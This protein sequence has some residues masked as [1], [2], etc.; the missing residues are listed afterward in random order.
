[1]VILDWHGGLQRA[2]RGIEMML[3]AQVTDVCCP[4]HHPINL[5]HVQALLAAGFRLVRNLEPPWNVGR[6]DSLMGNPPDVGRAL[7]EWEEVNRP[8][9]QFRA[10][11]GNLQRPVGGVAWNMEHLATHYPLTAADAAWLRE[12]GVSEER[13]IL[14]CRQFAVLMRLYLLH[15]QQANPQA[16]GVAYSGYPGLIYNR[17]MS[18]GQAYSVDWEMLVEPLVYRGVTLPPLSYAM[19]SV[20]YPLISEQAMERTPGSLKV[21]HALGLPVYPDDQQRWIDYRKAIANRIKLARSRPGDG[22]GIMACSPLSGPW[23]RDEDRLRVMIAEE[24]AK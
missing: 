19:M 7:M 24:L 16:I 6:D 5:P 3:R 9:R 11:V 2:Q 18:L 23:N 10:F 4:M 20:H 14:R 21:L 22:L 15:A 13:K 1:M 12:F 8:G 17:T